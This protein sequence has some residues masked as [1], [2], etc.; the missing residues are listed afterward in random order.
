MEVMC[1][2]AK[3]GGGWTMVQRTV[4]DPEETAALFTGGDAWV[5]TTIGEA[6]PDKAYRMA[7]KHWPT[8]NVEKRHMLAH[9]LRK[10]G[11]GS[12]CA[13]LYYTGDGGTFA[14]NGNQVTL[15]G[16]SSNVTMISNT[17]LST[18]DSGPSTGCINSFKGAP[19]FYSNCCNTCP[20][21]AG[22][23]WPD[24]H[25]MVSYTSTVSDIFGKS[26]AVVCSGEAPIISKGFQGAN[27]MEYYIR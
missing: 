12:S 23:Y 3:D 18:K 26:P 1:E 11:D 22:A 20:T 6:T 21:F 13:P 5:E 10:A 17:E 19:W 16:L 7:G 27:S 25:P 9:S 2:M 8:L 4:W 24:P 14:I 15:N